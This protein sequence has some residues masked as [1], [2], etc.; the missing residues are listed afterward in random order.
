MSGT[1]WGLLM[2]VREFKDD[3]DDPLLILEICTDNPSLAHSDNYAVQAL[4]AHIEFSH[5]IVNLAMQYDLSH[6]I[7]S[8][9]MTNVQLVCF[10]VFF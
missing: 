2:E 8:M 9:V 7:I 10:F 5:N 4:I 6:I 3:T 1:I